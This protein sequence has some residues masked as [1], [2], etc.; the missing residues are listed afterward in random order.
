M[1]IT[2][3][4]QIGRYNDVIG[5]ILLQIVY[6]QTST[7]QMKT[8]SYRSVKKLSH[9]LSHH[10]MTSFK[11][12]FS[13]SVI[14]FENCNNIIIIHI[15]I[16]LSCVGSQIMIFRIVETPP[17]LSRGDSPVIR[18]SRDSPTWNAVMNRIVNRVPESSLKRLLW[19]LDSQAS[20]VAINSSSAFGRQFRAR[21]AC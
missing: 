10:V 9:N 12:Y 3:H 19:T 16:G 1:P 18:R 8:W 2:R 4:V 17:E 14:V 20:S 6:I 7:S 5:S 11:F 15:Y 13:A 21:R